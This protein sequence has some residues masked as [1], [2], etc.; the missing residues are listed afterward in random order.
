[1][2]IKKI[3]SITAGVA[4]LAVAATFLAPREVTIERSMA[5]DAPVETILEFAAGNASY[6]AFNP[7]KDSDPNLQIDLFGPA[8]GV[9]SGF[10]FDSKDGAGTIV[11]EQVSA[12][13]VH[14]QL[15]LGPM[16]APTQ[17]IS[18]AQGANGNTITWQMEMDMGLNPIARVMGLFM[19]GMVGPSFEKGLQ[20]L[21]AVAS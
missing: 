18:V 21:S 17:T 11:I 19:D 6:Q 12:D 10:H 15:D 4:T 16:G 9:G 20:N 3:A 2:T 8:S 1:M 14:Y 5:T 13:A 7:F